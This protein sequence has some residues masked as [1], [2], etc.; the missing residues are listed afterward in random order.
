SISSTPGWTR[1]S[2]M[3]A[4]DSPLAARY[5]GGFAEATRRTWQQSI[6]RTAKRNPRIAVFATFLLIIWLVSV[7]APLIAPYNPYAVNTHN[8]FRSPSWSH[9]AGTDDLGRDTFT[10]PLHGGRLSLLVAFFVVAL[11]S[12][13]GLSVR[14]ITGY[15]G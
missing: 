10:R 7:S 6:W 3:S 1:G 8:L 12:T 9:L 14:L 5:T 2:A 15:Y 4:G 11:S 13:I